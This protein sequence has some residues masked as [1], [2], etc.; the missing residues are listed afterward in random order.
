MYTFQMYLL[1]EVEPNPNL[2]DRKQNIN[3]SKT[4]IP[5]HAL[6]FS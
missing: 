6:F 1:K 5:K 2:F 4:S 3:L